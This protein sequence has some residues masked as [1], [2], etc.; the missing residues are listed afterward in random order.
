MFA[1]Q[2]PA[3]LLLV[4]APV[5]ALRTLKARQLSAFV[6]HVPRQGRFLDVELVALRAAILGRS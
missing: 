5:R 1:N 2:V 3:K 4:I 6:A